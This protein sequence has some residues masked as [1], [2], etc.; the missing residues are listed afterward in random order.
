MKKLLLCML[1]I[2]QYSNIFAEQPDIKFKHLTTEN[3]LSHS[4]IKCIYRDS[5]GYMWFG[6]ANSGINRYDGNNFTS[7]KYKSG[8]INSLS[9]NT[10]NAICEDA[11]NTLWIATLKGLNSFNRDLDY[12]YTAPGT[13]TLNIEG[14]HSLKNG[15]LL[16]TTRDEFYS[17]NP[18]DN[19]LQE[20]ILDR[21]NLADD[22]FN[23]QMIAIDNDN[24]LIATRKG[25]YSFS[26][27]SKAFSKVIQNNTDNQ[28]IENLNVRSLLKDRK[29]RIWVGTVNNGLFCLAYNTK[30]DAL[31]VFIKNYMNDANNPSS[32]TKDELVRL[33]EDDNGYLWIATSQN[34]IDILGVNSNNDI[35]Y[36]YK[37]DLQDNYSI[38]SNSINSMYKDYEN[39]IWIGTFNAGINYYNPVLFKFT[40]VKYNHNNK[41]G[42]SEPGINA[43]YEDGNYLWLGAGNGLNRYDRKN[44]R[45]THFLPDENNDQ[46]LSANGVWAILR[47]SKGR[48]WLGTWAGGLNLFDDKTETF[49]HYKNDPKNPS[50]ISCNNIFGITEDSE[51]ILWVA[52]MGGGLDKFTPERN[53]FKSYIPQG[54]ET[55]ISTNWTKSVLETQNDEIWVATGN[56]IDIFNKKSEE[57]S[58]FKKEEGNPESL[59]SDQ[60]VVLYRDSKDNIW[61]GTEYGIN[62]F[63]RDNGTF[64]SYTEDDGLCNNVIRGICEDDDGD[65]WIS[66][67][68]G[69]S[70]FVNAV[71]R[72]DVAQFNNFYV[73]DGLQGDE[74]NSRSCFNGKN[75]KLYFGGSNG[76]NI[77]DPEH[78]NYNMNVPE[79]VL[80]G[81][82]LFYKPVVIGTDSSPLTKD[83]SCTQKI[84]L[85]HKQS[86]IRI[87]YAAL[88][89][90]SP[91]KNQYAFMMHGFEDNWNYVG[92]Q[93]FAT[94]TN[95]NPGKYSFRVKA[96]NN[97]G[98]WNERGA[99]LKIVIEPPFWSTWWFRTTSLLSIIIFI[100]AFY[101]VRTHNIRK[102]NKQLEQKVRERTNELVIANSELA[103]KKNL[104]QT[105]IDIIPDHIYIKD[106]MS[107]FILN[108][109]AHLQLLGAKKQDEV[110]GKTDMDF[111][112]DEL[113]NTYF[114][115]EQKILETGIS[116]IN[117]EE[118]VINL[119]TGRN[120]WVT[121]TK[122]RFEDRLGRVQGLVGI[123]HDITER[124]KFEEE[125]KQAKEDAESANRSKSEFL[126]NMSHEIRTPMNGV[127]GMTELVLDTELTKQQHDYLKIAKQSAESLL[128]L[129]NDILDFSKIEAG[130]LELEAIDFNLR[131]V[132]ETAVTTLAIQ[133]HSKKLELLLNIASNVPDILKGD[134]GRLRQI[135]VNLMG[136]AIKFTEKGE[137]V[138][139]VKLAE[140][141]KIGFIGI[142]VAV[143]DTGI[144]V[145][146]DKVDK[147]FES[148][149][150]VD[151]STT[152]K[153]GGTGLGLTI[154][155]KL[156]EMMNGKIWVESELGKG[157]TFQFTA[158]LK[159]GQLKQI[160]NF[161]EQFT[162]LG[163][164]RVLIVDDNN[165]NCIIVSEVL[166][167]Y[168]IDAATAWN[169]KDGLG[170]LYKATVEENLFDLILLDYQMPEMDG[171]EFTQKV[172]ANSKWDSIKIVMM[173]SVVDRRDLE[174]NNIVGIDEFLQKPVRQADLIQTILSAFGN[175]QQ[176]NETK[177]KN[178]N[179][180]NP[181]LDILLA[182]DN[183]VNQKV[184]TALLKKWGHTVTIANDGKEAVDALETHAYDLILMDVQMPN[185]DGLEATKIIRSS[186]SGNINTKI[187]IIAMTAHVMKG[188]R[189]R[190]LEAGM[191]DYI[192]KPINVQE[193]QKVINAVALTIKETVKTA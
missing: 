63:N 17:Y 22:F 120:H 128:D 90:L 135:V 2:I 69:I 134:P 187:P 150:Q 41:N 43:I 5:Y 29:G 130:R 30:S 122:V 137:I 46:S 3:G 28:E 114:N 105:L 192:S 80:T 112:P 193:V 162:E 121:A 39:T 67:N 182:E 88:N 44:N 9:N 189:E 190:F 167:F 154:S 116:K 107:R 191:D 155:Q 82:N 42:L 119:T 47:D 37:A 133:A 85:S 79:I 140:T 138:V 184:G 188:D 126:A 144:G 68:K 96:S 49:T 23:G 179:D 165:T 99:S 72:P 125:L 51:G 118:Q 76:Y 102:T 15:D 84:V 176:D 64:T 111:F 4:Y 149:S 1:V 73:D 171:F 174:Q 94:Y 139:Q 103:D 32:I 78:I 14:I 35:F 53:T 169:G 164:L 98:V 183:L 25:L 109:K 66:T 89:L 75:G 156:S 16:L 71:N 33:E 55:S 45:W 157:S 123:S 81:F 131:K 110:L 91:E 21:E 180:G 7:Y 106:K 97:D 48:L 153:Y 92:N 54:T 20:F 10:I 59:S 65:L 186:T 108:N 145:P 40:H 70:Q 87:E 124:K 19:T 117:E 158:Y 166:K 141:E 61:V 175:K 100:I 129:L 77:I 168:G 177:P 27:K 151:A 143:K 170:M 24:Y 12:F 104:L 148:F 152:R 161:K 185:M 146:A 13:S 38:S 101:H 26:T 113:S 50:S 163:K 56:G 60:I 34:G 127:I 83:I 115:D 159:P 86:V 147:I 178:E 18:A 74:F 6:T 11:N 52:T 93:N 142:H 173:S 57:F 181:K 31:P 160:D 58:H 36:H 136:N 62:R 8:D 95:L 132:F 172:R